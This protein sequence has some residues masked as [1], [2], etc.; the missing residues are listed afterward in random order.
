MMK[1]GFA[2]AIV[3]TVLF[4][5][6]CRTA[7]GQGGVEYTIHVDNDGSA[8]WLIEQ[9]GT[10]ITVSPYTLA[11]FQANV[12]AL[13]QAAEDVTHRQMAAPATSISITSTV[14]GSYVAVQYKFLWQNFSRM[15]PA[16]IK[17]DD[18][19]QVKD[20][21]PRLQG[22]GKVY[23]TYPEQYTPETVSPA[24]F[25][26]DDVHQTI[27]WLGTKNFVEESPSIILEEKPPDFL[28]LL[29]RNS[30]LIG[31]LALA[32]AGS[33]AGFI[34]YKRHKKRQSRTV[35]E[36]E[37]PVLSGIESGEEKIVKLLSSSGGT[38]R[39]STIVEQCRFSKAKTSQL[40]AALE[41]RRIVRREKR[42]RDKIVVLVRQNWE[43]KN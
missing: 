43:E 26:R 4:L 31:G 10:D 13:V 19:F 11:D 17:V 20:L 3:A 40:L 23:L 21:F 16:R 1:Y 28:G 5:F 39:Q 38:L 27:T 9:T 41:S 7:Q 37:A 6:L 29:N 35:S 33:S 36:P 32:A 8:T 22:D 30:T 24:P 42:G 14:S 34:L 12:T 2:V 15:E 18:V 25:S